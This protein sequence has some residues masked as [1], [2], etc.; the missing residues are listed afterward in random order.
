MSSNEGDQEHCQRNTMYAIVSS[1]R[2]GKGKARF[3]AHDLNKTILADH[4]K[5]SHH[6][7]VPPTH[8]VFDTQVLV[9][10]VRIMYHWCSIMIIYDVLMVAVQISKHKHVKKDISNGMMED[11]G[12]IDDERRGSEIEM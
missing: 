5:M 4:K 11:V 1:V 8:V 10:S 9:L 6:P 12:W 2:V 7:N 3:G